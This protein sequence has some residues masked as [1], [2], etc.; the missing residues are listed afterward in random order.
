[1]ASCILCVCVSALSGPGRHYRRH[2]NPPTPEDEQETRDLF[3]RHNR[4]VYGAVAQCVPEWLVNTLYMSRPND[5]RAALQHLR[6]EYGVNTSMDRA[7]A[8]AKLHRCY[9]DPRAA[10]DI[11]HVRYQYDSMREANSDLQNAGG[12]K[13]SFKM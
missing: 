4:Q 13:P 5:G 1:M 2:A 7:A 8:M 6:V 3:L 9:L 11:N 10:I 12:T